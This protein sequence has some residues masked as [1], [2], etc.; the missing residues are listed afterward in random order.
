V[1]TAAIPFLPLTL[2]VLPFEEIVKK[3]IGMLL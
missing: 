3:V 2:T 1:A